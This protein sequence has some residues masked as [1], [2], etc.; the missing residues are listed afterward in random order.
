MGEMPEA[1]RREY[2]SLNTMASTTHYHWQLWLQLYDGGEKVELLRRFG[3]IVFGRIQY[4]ML[5]DVVLGI[6]RLTD[7]PNVPSNQRRESLGIDRLI[8]AVEAADPGLPDRLKLR[9]IMKELKTRSKLFREIRNRFL[10][11]RD[12]ETWNQLGTFPNQQEID[13]ALGLAAKIMNAVRLHYENATVS[14][15]I[16]PSVG[17]GNDFMRQLRDHAH[18]LDQIPRPWMPDKGD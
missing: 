4:M 11:H 2:D 6:C 5:A 12:L 16:F 18:H 17:D 15:S 7:P 8:N 14:Y 10:A 1:V 9:E 13:E 3:G